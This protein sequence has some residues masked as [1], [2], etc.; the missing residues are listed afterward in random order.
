MEEQPLDYIDQNVSVYQQLQ[1]MIEESQKQIELVQ[2][3][4]FR[5]LTNYMPLLNPPEEKIA[6]VPE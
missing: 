5:Q 4:N 1:Q 2:S 3:Q 6:A